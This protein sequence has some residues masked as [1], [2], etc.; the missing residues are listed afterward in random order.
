MARTK[1]SF[2]PWDFLD[3]YRGKD[4]Y[5]NWPTVS[6]MFDITAKR[7]PDNMCFRVFVPKEYS[8]TYKEA[9]ANINKISS[10]LINDGVKPGD[11]IAVSGKNSPEWAT[12]YLS[13]LKAGAIIVPL[14]I[15][16]N[17]EDMLKLLTFG[18][19]SRI[20]IDGD[21]IEKLDPENTLNLKRYSLE[22]GRAS[23][24]ERV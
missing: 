24:R 12:A 18:D 17:D 4:F 6:E 23:C 20:F 3:E 7:Y 10:Y 16:Y 21:R 5:G 11:K 8:L 14:D 22:I 13:V 1:D 2:T 15:S 19:V 9:Q